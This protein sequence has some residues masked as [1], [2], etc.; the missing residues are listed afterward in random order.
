[1]D[2]Y[3]WKC[4]NVSSVEVENTISSICGLQD[5]A[6]YGVKIPGCDGQA[7][8]AAIADPSRSLDFDSLTAGIHRLLPHY[9]KPLFIRIVNQLEMTTTHKIQKFNLQ[10]QGFDINMVKDPLFFQLDGK[11]VPLESDLYEQIV[12]EKLKL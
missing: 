3:R 8:M 11:Y 10:K 12:S 4:E 9:A 6:V 5:V 1:M 2:N 7:G